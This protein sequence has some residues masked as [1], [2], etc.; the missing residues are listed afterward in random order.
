MAREILHVHG[1]SALGPVAGVSILCTGSATQAC[2]RGRLL[3][4]S[5]MLGCGVMVARACGLLSASFRAVLTTEDLTMPR[6][7][8]SPHLHTHV[9][10][11]IHKEIHTCT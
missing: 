4:S 3:G 8:N 11:Y 10:I 5:K 7:G 9:Y 1:L 6:S 2:G